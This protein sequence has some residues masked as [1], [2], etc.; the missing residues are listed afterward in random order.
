MPFFL[1]KILLLG[2]AEMTQ[3]EECLLLFQRTWVWAPAPTGQLTIICDS[4][5]KG[6]VALSG[7]HEHH[8]H[9]VYI[10]THNHIL[11]Y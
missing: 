5:F 7:L 9:T 8:T 4:N 10:Y 3:S 1:L 11:T 2:A 6:C